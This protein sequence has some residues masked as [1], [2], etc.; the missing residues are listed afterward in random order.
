MKKKKKK[1]KKL[2]SSWTNVEANGPF[3]VARAS[4]EGALTTNGN[5]KHN[6]NIVTNNIHSNLEIQSTRSS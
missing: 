4:E 6:N 2:Q 1:K 5:T 3:F